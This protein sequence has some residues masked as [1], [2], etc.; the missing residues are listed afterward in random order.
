MCGLFYRLIASEREKS[1][2]K[3]HLLI[4]PDICK[5]NVKIALCVVIIYIAVAL[6]IIRLRIYYTCS[7]FTEY[8]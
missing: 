4:F 1:N 3:F 2:P 7:Y 8:D 5:D 6:I